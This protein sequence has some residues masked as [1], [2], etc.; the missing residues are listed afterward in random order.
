M[1]SNCL[2]WTLAVAAVLMGL[3][4]AAWSSPRFGGPDAVENQ[5]EEDEQEKQPLFDLDLLQPYRDWKARVQEKTGIHFGGD[6]S[7]QAFFADDSPLSRE[8]GEFVCLSRSPIFEILKRA[9]ATRWRF[10]PPSILGDWPG[11]GRAASPHDLPAVERVEQSQRPQQQTLA[12]ARG[13]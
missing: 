13:T 9:N 1:T 12:A 6:Y 4:G 3:P 11:K 7:A 2:R 10:H 5:L 8:Q